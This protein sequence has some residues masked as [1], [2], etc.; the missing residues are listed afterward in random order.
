M[1]GSKIPQMPETGRRRRIIQ[2]CVVQGVALLCALS[3]TTGCELSY[4]TKQSLAKETLQQRLEDLFTKQLDQPIGPIDCPE[5]LE[6]KVGVTTTCT[7]V[8]EGRDLEVA[9]EVSDVEG[10]D[11]KFDATIQE[12]AAK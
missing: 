12:P 11:I 10:S 9:V 3:L 2:S 4:S 5:N 6:G 7:F 8:H 1:S